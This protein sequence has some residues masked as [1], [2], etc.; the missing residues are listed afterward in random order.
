MQQEMWAA[1]GAESGPWLTASKETGI[2]VQ[3]PRGNKFYQPLVSLEE[4]PEH[5]L[6]TAALLTLIFSL[7]KT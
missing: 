1:A 7:A 2:S 4:D 5:Q 3:Q 6:R